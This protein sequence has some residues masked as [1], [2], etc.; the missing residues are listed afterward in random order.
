MSRKDVHSWLKMSEE[1]KTWTIEVTVRIEREYPA[2][3][4]ERMVLFHCNE[5]SS[6]ANNLLEDYLRQLAEKREC[7]CW[8]TEARVVK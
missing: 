1:K 6:C 4:D 7:A 5:S 3:W 8:S 2:D